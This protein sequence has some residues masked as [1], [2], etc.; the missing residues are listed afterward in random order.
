MCSA[1]E[2]NE[3][4]I[5]I[6]AKRQYPKTSKTTSEKATC[7]QNSH[8]S[9]QKLQTSLRSDQLTFVK[10]IHFCEKLEDEVHKE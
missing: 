1:E 9:Q 4:N 3:K 10:N 8:K 7:N 6:S 5:I 2:G